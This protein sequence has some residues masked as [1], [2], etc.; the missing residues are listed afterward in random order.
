[1]DDIAF[2]ENKVT[3]KHKNKVAALLVSIT[4]KI[5]LSHEELRIL[6]VRH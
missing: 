3:K 2:A 1:M 4:F 5:R 6:D